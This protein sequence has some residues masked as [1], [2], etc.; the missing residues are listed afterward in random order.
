[1]DAGCCCRLTGTSFERP[2]A[3]TLGC[4]SQLTLRPFSVSGLR[5]SL[6][7][8][9]SVRLTNV[10]VQ[11]AYVNPPSRAVNRM[12]ISFHVCLPECSCSNHNW[13]WWTASKA[14]RR[15]GSSFQDVLQS[16]FFPQ[17]KAGRNL[18]HE[19]TRSSIMQFIKNS[20][21]PSSVETIPDRSV[22]SQRKD[23][24]SANNA[25]VQLVLHRVHTAVISRTIVTMSQ[26]I[27]LRITRYPWHISNFREHSYNWN[28]TGNGTYQGDDQ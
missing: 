20:N 27:I 19:K 28:F 14:S 23:A 26:Y 4:S 21:L 3:N 9:R 17:N 6:W 11:Q 16:I 10:Y 1:M 2:R 24:T 22:V 5:P 15:H 18:G 25:D 8:P 13:A 7:R 12:Q